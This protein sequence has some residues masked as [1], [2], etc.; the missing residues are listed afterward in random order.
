MG[1]IERLRNICIMI[2]LIKIEYYSD[3]ITLKTKLK[4]TSLL[5]SSVSIIS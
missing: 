3:N 2:S 1:V 4:S 5:I